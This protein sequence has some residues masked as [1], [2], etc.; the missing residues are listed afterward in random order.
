VLVAMLR[1]I[2]GWYGQQIQKCMPMV[3]K[4]IPVHW[5]IKGQRLAMMRRLKEKQVL[6]QVQD[7]RSR[8]ICYCW[9]R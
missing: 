8:N 5:S 7:S 6:W 9:Y 4:P 1:H 3:L 2:G